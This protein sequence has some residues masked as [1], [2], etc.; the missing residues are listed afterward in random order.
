MGQKMRRVASLGS[1]VNH[2]ECSTLVTKY[3]GGGGLAYVEETF[4]A[5]MNHFAVLYYSCQPQGDFFLLE[6][7]SELMR[8]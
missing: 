1:P 5:D 4:P 3:H 6:Q 2:I 7:Y 8:S